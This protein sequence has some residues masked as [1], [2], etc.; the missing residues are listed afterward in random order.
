MKAV[1]GSTH[2][3]FNPAACHSTKHGHCHTSTHMKKGLVKTWSHRIFISITNSKPFT[4]M[5]HHNSKTVLQTR[6]LWSVSS[7][8]WEEGADRKG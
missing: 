6:K 7:R 1:T 4:A 2:L 3:S 8:G 5:A